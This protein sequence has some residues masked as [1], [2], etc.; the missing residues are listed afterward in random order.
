MDDSRYHILA[1]QWLAM[2]MDALEEADRNAALEV[3]CEGGILTILL[4]SGKALVVSKHGV[5][6]QL[7]LS[8]P[9]SGGLH[10]SYDASAGCWK[11]ADGRMLDKVLAEE[12][13]AF[14]VPGVRFS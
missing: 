12:L 8:S 4:P 6:R 1:D 9:E 11:L 10:F 2:A 3:E 14:G 13:A 5:T 7:W